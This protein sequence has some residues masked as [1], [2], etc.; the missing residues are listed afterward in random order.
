MSRPW[1]FLNQEARRGTKGENIRS[2]RIHK[3]PM[4][5]QPIQVRPKNI[6]P[7]NLL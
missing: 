6:R 4:S 1:Y 3:K 7:S 5:N 2:T